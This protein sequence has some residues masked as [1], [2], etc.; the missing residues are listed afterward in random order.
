MKH[1]IE[2][3]NSLIKEELGKIIL[4]E[5]ELDGA[6]VTITDIRASKNLTQ[7]VVG[8]SVIPSSKAGAALKMIAK[9]APYLQSLLAK[10]IVL[11]PMPKIIFEL[12]RGLEKAARVE[13]LLRKE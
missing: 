4:K 11:R 1:R 8:I 9:N 6:L 2:R 10:N 3:V 7:A 5:M 12:D 13:E